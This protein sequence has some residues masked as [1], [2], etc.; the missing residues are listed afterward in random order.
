[1]FGW[2]EC[3][4]ERLWPLFRRHA[5]RVRSTRLHVKFWQLSS[6]RLFPLV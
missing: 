2:A 6:P 4:D 3:F 1:V 5:A